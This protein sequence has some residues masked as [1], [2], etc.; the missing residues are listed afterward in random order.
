M[1]KK[2]QG[3]V[4][5]IG[6]DTTG[7][8][9]ALSKVDKALSKTQSSLRDVNKLLKLDP[10]NTI[11]LQQKYDLLQEKIAATEEKLNA[12]KQADKLAKAQLAS[13]DL[14][15]DKYDALQREIIETT[16]SLKT[17]KSEVGSG[18]AYFAK[19]GIGA[20]NLG[21]S[22]KSASDKLRPLS[23]A[24]SSLAAAA[25]ATVPATEELRTDLSKLD[26][27]AKEA[28]VGFDIAREAFNSF[29]V[30]SDEVD[31]SV[32]ATSNLLQAGFT[33]SNLQ[34][35]VEGL[36]GAYLRFPDTLK[37]ESLADSLQE[38]IATGEAT[39]QFGELLD[40][41]GIGAENFSAGLASCSTEAQKQNYALTTLAEAGLMETYN[42]WLQNNEELV[43]SKEAS[44]D[45]QM[46]IA[47][48]AE[49]LTPVVT[50]I[51]EFATK[52]IDAFNNLPDGAKEAIAIFVLIVAVLSPLLSMVGSLA[53]GFGALMKAMSKVSGVG[54]TIVSI[55][56]KIGKAVTSLFT[57]IAAHPVAAVITAIVALLVTL[58]TKCEWFRNG[59]NSAL[60]K[61]GE[62]FYSLGEKVAGALEKASEFMRDAGDKIRDTASRMATNVKNNFEQMKNTV[63]NTVEKIRTT[64]VNAFNR[65]GVGIA[66]AASG[67]F[68]G[69]KTALSGAISYVK[70]LKNAALG[71]G[72]D[73]M[74]G[75]KN[76]ITGAYNKVKSAAQ[77][78]ASSI[79]RLLHFSRP[80][81]G[82]LRNYET[83]MPDFMDGLAKGIRSNSF[84]VTDAL[85]ALT[86]KMSINPSMNMYA[87]P[88]KQN[89][90]VSSPDVTVMVGNKEFKGYIVQTAKSGI[91]SDMYSYNRGKGVYA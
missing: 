11:L 61:V 60:Q 20:D 79:S 29:V 18:S 32:E 14:G 88:S 22:A 17:L 48:L 56:G 82:P 4:I 81:E 43:K 19:I 76:G 58:Y 78:V 64:A 13:G 30:A 57:L 36:T 52:L 68:N 45:F 40:R 70:N 15:K 2:I 23:T 37:I 39:G 67:I 27:N 46:A 63:S 10:G 75:F 38:T 16:E 91:A 71:W 6:G 44:Q 84:K 35:A 34:K 3:I 80:D 28:G 5:E 24:A 7:L 72:R 89:I 55:V 69:A 62:A 42:G 21:K 50:K 31:S 86:E 12:L 77:G 53:S 54:G 65:I 49:A 85:S 47:E 8:S 87:E 1:S 59:V 9:K 83:W 25:L 51:T 90:S 26:A 66:G 33:E 74:E 41:L 73:M